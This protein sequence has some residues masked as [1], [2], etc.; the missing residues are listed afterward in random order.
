MQTLKDLSWI[1]W[2][3]GDWLPNVIGGFIPK[4]AKERQDTVDKLTTLTAR[5][6]L[7]YATGADFSSRLG[8][9]NLE[10]RNASAGRTAS[11]T[12]K[13]FIEN[14]APPSFNQY[15]GY[16]DAIHAYRLGDT[17]TAVEKAAPASIRNIA[18]AYEL[19]TEGAKDYK[20][21]S[22]L[23]KNAV[24]TGQLIWRVVG[25]NSDKLADLQGT[26]F[27]MGAIQK[28]MLNERTSIMERFKVA[29]RLNNFDA[30]TKALKEQQKYNTKYPWDQLET[31]SIDK[32]IEKA[33]E[34]RADSWRGISITE[35]NEPYATKAVAPS[36][37]AAVK[38]EQETAKDKK[39]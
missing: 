31:E 7:N 19:A 37:R 3:K 21:A 16:L 10:L 12:V 26:N 30:Y 39:P 36:R 38:L 25:F 22:L 24:T 29:D 8:I 35:K 27:R 11:E 28:E 17:Q 32:E 33:R 13:S 2:F 14:L 18:L 15:K 4:D 5:G 20:G 1:D 23:N 6:G 9:L 34:E